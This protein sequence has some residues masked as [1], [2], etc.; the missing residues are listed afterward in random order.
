M[1]TPEEK[2]AF[3]AKQDAAIKASRL[4]K[5]STTY[6]RLKYLFYVTVRDEESDWAKP[7]T[8]C[9]FTDEHGQIL[10][11]RKIRTLGHLE[12]KDTFDSSDSDEIFMEKLSKGKKH[13]VKGKEYHIITGADGSAMQVHGNGLAVIRRG[14][15][16]TAHKI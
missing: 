5:P 6:M 3:I 4:M 12:Y 14:S 9:L 7:K 8:F 10:R 11:I 15:K 16:I 13:L 1:L 2:Q